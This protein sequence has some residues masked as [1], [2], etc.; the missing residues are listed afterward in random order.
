MSSELLGIIAGRGNIVQK[1]TSACQEQSHPF[2]ILAFESQADPNL[3]TPHPHTWLQLAKAGKT[4]KTCKDLGIKKVVMAGYFERPRWNE[5]KPDLTGMKL[6]SKIIGQPLGDDGLLRIIIAFFEEE[7]IEVI[8]T[9]DLLGSSHLMPKGVLTNV[10]PTDEQM[11]DINHGFAIAKETGRLDIGQGV[12]V[13]NGVIM[14]VEALEGT[15]ELIK[16][17]RSLTHKTGAPDQKPIYV[18]VIKPTQDTRVDRSVIGPATLQ[19]LIKQDYAGLAAETNEVI[20]VD[21]E[22]CINLANQN[23][24]FIIGISQP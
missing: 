21:Q 1:L 3:V 8:S 11:I 19:N 20:I 13:S 9:E 22:E 24:L 6:L 17:C 16:R 12:V 15:D 5:L 10:A 18:K 2:H 23:N 4:I 7:G 14:G